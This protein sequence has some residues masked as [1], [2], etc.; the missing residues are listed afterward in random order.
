MAGPH[1]GHLRISCPGLSGWAAVL[2]PR[3]M[4]LFGLEQGLRRPTRVGG[5][6][7]GDPQVI[8]RGPL[9]LFEHVTLLVGVKHD[10]KEGVLGR[11]QQIG[12]GRRRA[13]GIIGAVRKAVSGN[14]RHGQ[15]R[16]RE[17]EETELE[18]VAGCVAHSDGYS[19]FQAMC[20]IRWCRSQRFW[21]RLTYQP[22]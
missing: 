9:L 22:G 15:R 2:T 5:G 12:V 18:D 7:V 17:Q 11:G 1:S 14:G 6:P 19:G 10:G 3:P 8:G 21:Y 4:L 16:H 20:G 13:C